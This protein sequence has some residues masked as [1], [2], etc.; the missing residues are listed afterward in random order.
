MSTPVSEQ[1]TRLVAETGLLYS[2]KSFL[3]NGESRRLRA[4]SQG[5]RHGECARKPKVSAAVGGD[6]RAAP[7]AH[8]L[9][10]AA[11][12][13]PCRLSTSATSN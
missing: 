1:L 2:V 6:I 8:R 3:L 12:R 13:T 5:L 11:S 4:R 7:A 10:R 9:R